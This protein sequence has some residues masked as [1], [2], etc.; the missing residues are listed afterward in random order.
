MNASANIEAIRR[1]MQGG[2]V[3]RFRAAAMAGAAG[4]GTFLLVY[5][6]MRG[7]SR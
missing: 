2:E 1:R 5:K 7:Q 4:T 6:T 3:S